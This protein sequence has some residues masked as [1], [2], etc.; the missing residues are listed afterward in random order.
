MRDFKAATYIRL[1]KRSVC[2]CGGGGGGG[3]A[4][5]LQKLGNKSEK[6][7]GNKGTQANF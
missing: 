1:S 5:R 2:V 4:S 7:Y 6:N 3:G